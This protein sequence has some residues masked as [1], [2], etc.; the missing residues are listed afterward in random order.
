MEN[1][2]QRFENKKR[3]M[4]K[5]LLEYFLSY[6]QDT[7]RILHTLTGKAIDYLD[8]E[9][10]QEIE[11]DSR[12]LD[13][14]VL[15]KNSKELSHSSNFN[16]IILVDDDYIQ[17]MGSIINKFFEKYKIGYIYYEN[18]LVLNIACSVG[19]F[20]KALEAY[21]GL[22]NSG[23]VE[24]INTKVDNGLEKI[25]SEQTYLEDYFASDLHS[26]LYEKMFL[27]KHLVEIIKSTGS[28]NNY[29]LPDINNINVYNKIEYLTSSTSKAVYKNDVSK[30][31]PLDQIKGLLP[32]IEDF[33]NR[34]NLGYISESKRASS[35][36]AVVNFTCSLKELIDA[37]YMEKQRIMHYTSGDYLQ[38]P[39]ESA[40]RVK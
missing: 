3:K 12:Y 5:E 30:I 16:D 34:Y 1:L 10:Y 13:I 40:K 26:D 36:N 11:Y 39:S 21:Y 4:N 38:E 33:L 32:L 27:D 18:G 9:K 25:N 35:C 19:T 2:Y 31:L 6:Q 17:S 28:G 23:L 7:Q 29:I 22:I 24:G 20:K 14:S 8:N 15:V 37:Y